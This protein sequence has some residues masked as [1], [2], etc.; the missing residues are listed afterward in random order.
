MFYCNNLY[1]VNAKIVDYIF[2]SHLQ[3]NITTATVG[4]AMNNL[5][6]IVG[7]TS[8]TSDQNSDNLAVVDS[9]LSETAALLSGTST[10]LDINYVK[11]VR[12]GIE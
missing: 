10:S 6:A 4:M 7:S 1:S 2:Y 5:T 12:V 9:V 8:E 3:A 11:E